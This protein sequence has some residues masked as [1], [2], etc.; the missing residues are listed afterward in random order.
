MV[1]PRILV[2]G[3]S[4]YIGRS[5]CDYLEENNFKIIRSSSANCDFLNAE[6][7]K[8]FFVSLPE[9]SYSIVF[10]S[11]INQYEANSIVGFEKNIRIMRN[12]IDN[13]DLKNIS[14]II[15]FSTVKVYGEG[16]I[17]PITETIKTNPD[18]WYSIAKF[19][20]EWMLSHFFGEKIPVTILRI[21]GIYGAA[22]REQSVIGNFIKNIFEHQKVTIFG[23]GLAKRDYVYLGDLVQIVEQLLLRH[24]S[25]S[26]QTLNIATGRAHSILEILENIRSTLAINFDVEY[27]SK[28]NN[29]FDLCFDNG[30]LSSVLPSFHFKNLEDGLSSYL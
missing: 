29:N 23:T 8:N 3:S 26:V 13:I 10:L 6:S 9:K 30:K 20:C 15:Y 12:F 24:S 7:V 25:I 11:T 22:P 19:N 16:P 17:L 27:S 4:S 2:F 5:L 1:K 28:D 21:P 14:N 18:D